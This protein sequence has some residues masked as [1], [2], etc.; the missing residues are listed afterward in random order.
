MKRK[1]KITGIGLFLLLLSLSFGCK[2]AQNSA[3]KT[4]LQG[5]SI[6]YWAVDQSP[7]NAHWYVSVE[8]KDGI[9]RRQE[10]GVISEVSTVA[11][12]RQNDE[13]VLSV[14]DAQGSAVGC[15]L[16]R[17]ITSLALLTFHP[18]K[19]LHPGDFILKGSEKE[20][21]Q[22]FSRL[23]PGEIGVRLKVGSNETNEK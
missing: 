12:Q 9:L 16:G 19:T 2:D 15:R 14:C 13:Y 21:N 1:I 11:L 8:S 7:Q 22:N 20:V 17:E 10:L 5:L 6:K 18:P 23:D 4:V 3:E